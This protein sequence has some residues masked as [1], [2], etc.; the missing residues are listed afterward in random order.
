[1]VNRD[2][3]LAGLLNALLPGGSGFPPARELGMTEA[4]AVRLGQ[5]EIDPI[6]AFATFLESHGGV[7]LDATS[8][9]NIVL[10]FEAVEP[11]LFGELRKY[12][13]LTYYEQ[14]AAIDAIRALGFRYN[15]APL[16]EGYPDEPFTPDC[17][18]PRHR[19]GRWI[20]TTDMRRVD[21]TGLGLED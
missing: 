12:S 10:R 7:P 11:G 14:P 3:A 4:L 18:A 13:Y 8:W 9:H 20:S 19:R 1:M 17:D 2:A 15:Y 5:I 6:A 21:L 16:P